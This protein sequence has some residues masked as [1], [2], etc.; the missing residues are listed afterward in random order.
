MAKRRQKPNM[1]LA[2]QAMVKAS[3]SRFG[4]AIVRPRGPNKKKRRKK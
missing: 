2:K 4:F 1:K 3:K